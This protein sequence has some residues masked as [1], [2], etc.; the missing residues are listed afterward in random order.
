MTE[1]LYA[2]IL[3]IAVLL[4][5]MQV[6][7]RVSRIGCSIGLLV[8]GGLLLATRSSW[9]IA[10]VLWG[11]ALEIVLIDYLVKSRRVFSGRLPRLLTFA[12][13]QGVGVTAA[14]IASR[15]FEN[16]VTPQVDFPPSNEPPTSIPLNPNDLFF[17]LRVSLDSLVMS[18]RQSIDL[19][20][21]ASILLAASMPL[22]IIW[23]LLKAPWRMTYFVLVNWFFAMTVVG[24]VTLCCG[25][26]NSFFRY[27]IPAMF[28]TLAVAWVAQAPARARQVDSR[29]EASSAKE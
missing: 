8:C 26:L 9:P 1:G 7:G 28:V 12:V 6:T 22:L 5:W 11:F 3:L 18:V 25:G 15:L 24:I 17:I 13:S 29:Q 16:L 14:L 23:V 4:L 19:T 27:Q 20:D 10:G 2:L 21:P